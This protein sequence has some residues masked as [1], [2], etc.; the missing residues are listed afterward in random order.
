MNAREHHVIGKPPVWS[1]LAQRFHRFDGALVDRY[2]QD[3]E[4]EDDAR[5]ASDWRCCGP[6][7]APPRN[8]P[9]LRMRI[10]AALRRAGQWALDF[11]HPDPRQRRIIYIYLL[12]ATWAVMVVIGILAKHGIHP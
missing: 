4:R 11:I 8:T 10:R 2:M 12:V 1:R 5:L 3:E 7:W 9:G 6:A